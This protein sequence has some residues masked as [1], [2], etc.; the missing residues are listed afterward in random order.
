M[1]GLGWGGLG[2]ARERACER[3][4]CHLRRPEQRAAEERGRGVAEN[5]KIEGQTW[6]NESD[7]V[8][9]REHVQV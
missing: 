4:I 8:G 5:R 9:R 6:L 3:A 1:R 2:V 7:L